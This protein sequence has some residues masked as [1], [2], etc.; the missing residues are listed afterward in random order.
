M[1][2]AV[3]ET[4]RDHL[5]RDRLAIATRL[6]SAEADC[7]VSVVQRV[8]LAVTSILE[9]AYACGDADLAAVAPDVAIPAAALMR[10]AAPAVADATDG[11]MLP[12]RVY[13]LLGAAS[14]LLTNQGDP[15]YHDRIDYAAMLAAELATIHHS[16]SIAERGFPMLRAAR[17]NTA[18]AAP[19]D[20]D[21]PLN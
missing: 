6:L 20:L 15:F 1:Q 14:G 13:F 7:S 12:E 5:V 2:L 9:A 8:S 21:K 3:L 19:R 17:I 10:K 4:P 16:H 18:W 11:K